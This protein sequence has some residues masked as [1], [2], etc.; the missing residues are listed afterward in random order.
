MSLQK[1]TKTLLAATI[2]SVGLTYGGVGASAV[3]TK[4]DKVQI[5]LTYEQKQVGITEYSDT[6]RLKKVPY[7]KNGTTAKGFDASGFVQHVYGK[8]NVKLPRTSAE[9]QKVG[10]EVSKKNLKPGD[11]VFY[12]TTGKKTKKASFVGIYLGHNQ[13]SAVTVKKGVTIIN[14]NDKYW[15]KLYLGA[16]RVIN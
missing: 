10:K 3:T 14:L 13:I 11:L 9:M 12:N 4:F 16:K 15:S 2:L 8:F 7:K 5:N 6:L 1:G